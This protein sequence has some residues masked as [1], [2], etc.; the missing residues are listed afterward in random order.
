MSQKAILAGGSGL[1]G[2][3]LARRLAARGWEVVIL[4]RDPEQCHSMGDMA[5]GTGAV[6]AVQWDGEKGGKWTAELE[7]AAALVNLAGRSISCVFTLENSREILESRLNAVHALGK[8]LA[9]CK[10]PPA[11]WVQA[12]AVGLYGTTGDGV[13]DEHTP[14]ARDF[15][16]EVCRQWEDAARAACP[17][18]TRQ[19]LLRLGVVLD[20][21]GGA[22]PVLARLVRRCLGGTAGSGAQGFSWVHSDDA[23]LA[24]K[25][26]MLVGT[27]TGAYNVCAPNPVSNAELMTALRRALH[28]PWVPAAPEFVVRWAA[29]TLMQTDPTLVLGGRPCA[30]R[31]LLAEGFRF[32]FPELDMA[33]RDLAGK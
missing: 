8:A 18:A 28:R 4:T 3:T 13:C 10:Q 32:E 20:R 26:A 17:P 14:P 19:V 25:Q 2:Q 22:Y 24:F 12:S 11:V 6:R 23:I 15:L 7:G 29:V 9:K 16:A 31:R 1:L 21:S 27:M 30:P 33:L 5:A